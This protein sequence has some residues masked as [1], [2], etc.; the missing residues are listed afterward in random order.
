MYSFTRKVIK[1]RGQID[2][3]GGNTHEEGMRGHGSPDLVI[4][5]GG[6]SRE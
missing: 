5:G 4:R 1:W 6:S 2:R 3:G